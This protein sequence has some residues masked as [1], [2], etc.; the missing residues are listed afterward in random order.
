[1]RAGVNVTI[2]ILGDF[3]NL[4][5]KKQ[6]FDHLFVTKCL[7]TYLHNKIANFFSNFFQRNVFFNHN[8]GP[9][10]G[11]Q[12]T[13]CRSTNCWSTNCRSTNCQLTNCR[14]TN[15]WSTNCWSTNCRLMNC[16][17]TNCRS[18]NSRSTM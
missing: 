4:L 16:Q 13:N 10:L 6:C 3:V 9:R 18:T 1:V 8:I 17:S 11:Q 2:T 7:P 14:S 5:R 12:Q 15:C